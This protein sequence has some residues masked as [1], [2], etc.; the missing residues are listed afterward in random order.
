MVIATLFVYH[1]VKQLL[2]LQ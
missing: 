1:S 2:L